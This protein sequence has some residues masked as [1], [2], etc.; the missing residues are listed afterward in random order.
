MIDLERTDQWVQVCENEGNELKFTK[1]YL[2]VTEKLGGGAR[3]LASYLV[4]NWDSSF[5]GL[6]DYF[7][8]DDI[9]DDWYTGIDGETMDVCEIIPQTLA[10][11]GKPSNHLD[12]E[13]HRD[14]YR[15]KLASIK[16][17]KKLLE[18]YVKAIRKDQE[19]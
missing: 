15:A 5:K 8:P 16:V 6:L 11:E 1:E 2:S 12:E 13:W 19:R 7:G 10:V 3:Q 14:L 9:E 17:P 18:E 4:S